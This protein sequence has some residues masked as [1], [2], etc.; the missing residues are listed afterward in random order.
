VAIRLEI[1]FPPGNRIFPSNRTCSCR[2]TRRRRLPRSP[3]HSATAMGI[4]PPLRLARSKATILRLI[5]GVR[6][7]PGQDHLAN[8]QDRLRKIDGSGIGEL[9]WKRRFL[10]CT[11]RRALSAMMVPETMR[12]FLLR[13]DV[14]LRVPFI[15]R[16][17]ASKLGTCRSTSLRG[18]APC[19][20]PCRV[21]L[22]A[23][24]IARRCAPPRPRGDSVVAA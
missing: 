7:A 14:L 9:T 12:P 22:T 4:P 13:R 16:R 19:N 8:H 5:S 24:P 18:K 2:K 11:R 10:Y 3:I 6:A 21:F 15:R 20:A 1:A 17:V 23:P